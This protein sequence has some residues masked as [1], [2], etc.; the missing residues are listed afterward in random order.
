MTDLNAFSET[1]SVILILSAALAS[2]WLLAPYLTRVFTRSASRLDRL[3]LPIEKLTYRILGVDESHG[4]NWKEYFFAALWLNVAQMVIAFLILVFQ[5]SLPMNPQGF[6]GMSWDLALN[7]VVSFATNTNLQHYN[8]EAALSY[9]S[10]M[11]AIQFLQFTSAVTG[12]CVAVAMIRGFCLG[13]GFRVAERHRLGVAQLEA[14]V[15]HA[16]RGQV[17]CRRIQHLPGQVERDHLADAGREGERGV[18]AA[19]RHVQHAH[20]LRP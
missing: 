2:A 19:G 15:V 6:P 3:V 9:L 1:V 8:G 10:Q 18:A 4:M 11:A 12:I 14:D 5:A 20:P 7:T 13:G 16:V 17:A